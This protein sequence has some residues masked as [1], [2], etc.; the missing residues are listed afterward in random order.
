MDWTILIVLAGL[1]LISPI[2]LLIALIV[3]RHQL[4]EARRQLAAW[5]RQSSDESPDK[6]R[7]SSASSPL[8]A[9]AKTPLQPGPPSIKSAPIALQRPPTPVMRR[10]ESIPSIQPP[11]RPITASRPVTDAPS[12]ADWR[13]TEPGRLEEALR[14]MSGWPALIAPF[15]VQNI[16][17]FIGGFCFVAGA[18]FLVANTTGFINALVVFASLLTT[19]A[20][21]I[22]AGYQFRRARPELVIASRVLLTLGLM[23]GPLDLAVAVRLF[24][25]SDGQILWLALSAILALLT[26]ATFAWMARLASAL[27][28]RALPGRYT[29]LLVALAGIQLAAPLAAIVPDWWMLAVL[30]IALLV[31][32]GDGLRRFVS[33]WL[34]QIFVD[35]QWTSYFAVGMLVYSGTI[36]F[37]HLNWIWPDAL[38]AGYSGPFLMALCLLL[39][40]VDAA[41]KEWMHKY[42]FLSRFSFAL[43]SLSV[44]AVVMAIPATPTALL[45]LA[46]GSALYGWMTWR[47]L[48]PLPLYLLLACVVGLYGYGVL[49]W[50]PP[51]WHLLAS[52]PGLLALLALSRGAYLKTCSSQNSGF[53]TITRQCLLVFGL[54][55]IGLTVWSLLWASPGWIGFTTAA[56]AALLGYGVT[57]WALAWPEADPKWAYVD[58]GA[59]VAAAAAVAYAP[60][61]LLFDWAMQTALGWL[62]LAALWTGLSL[63]HQRPSSI[64][65]RV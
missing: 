51:M 64:S 55:L 52:L 13:P 22:W 34:R 26:L 18:L 41:L 50:L 30:H 17:W 48:T 32:L 35:R 40:P 53:L 36:S 58:A 57:R 16:G 12:A 56:S 28:D 61:R 23:L 8:P 42:A 24:N 21:L 62:A 5:E 43:Y 3:S 39:F 60:D 2:V 37:V 31:L 65:Q 59:A 1:W 15:L 63:Y 20:F 9:I 54:L 47:Y 46:L 6:G 38:P 27:I 19:T 4:A 33:Q 11:P 29:G 10:T 7:F 44:V 25:T 45:T 14:A 49:Q